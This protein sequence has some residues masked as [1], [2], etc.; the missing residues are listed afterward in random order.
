VRFIM[1]NGRTPRPRSLCVMCDQPVG[2][3]YL[4]EIGTHLI[5]CDHNCYESHCK[6]V[7]LLLENRAIA[8]LNNPAFGDRS[9]P[10]GERSLR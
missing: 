9:T 6:S 7:V 10:S 4:R 5:Y 1:A 3:N 8:S 2:A